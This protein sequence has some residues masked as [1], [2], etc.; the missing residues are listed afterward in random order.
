MG[1]DDEYKTTVDPLFHSIHAFQYSKSK[2]N[3]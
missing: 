1:P 3:S 2:V